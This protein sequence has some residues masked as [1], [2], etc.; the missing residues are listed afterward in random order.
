MQRLGEWAASADSGQQDLLQLVC[1]LDHLQDVIE[2]PL[3]A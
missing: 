3:A 1:E 2:P